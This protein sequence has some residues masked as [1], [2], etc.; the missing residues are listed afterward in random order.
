[1]NAIVTRNPSVVLINNHATTSSTAVAEYFG[2]RH[3]DVLRAIDN[4]IADISAEVCQR[5]F[6]FSLEIVAMPKG[7]TREQRV[8]TLTRDGFALLAMG[9]TGKEALQW[10]IAYLDA[11]NKMEAAL[12]AKAQPALPQLI[13]PAQQNALQ[14]VVTSKVGDAGGLR[15]YVWSRFNNHFHL[16]SYK[17]LPAEYFDEAMACLSTLPMKHGE[18]PNLAPAFNAETL[19]AAFLPPDGSYLVQ[20]QNG[21][22]R[23]PKRIGNSEAYSFAAE[24]L[25]KLISSPGEIPLALLPKI[26]I[27][28]ATRLD[29]LSA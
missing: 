19:N 2:K 15:A 7:G 29:G 10:K 4:L 20:I 16:G 3:S 27:A 14:Q 6:A 22:V 17:Q 9:F 21:R 13:T 23:N 5:N 8:F 11:F 24:D 1:M 26:I 18:L 25:P 12:I 28:C